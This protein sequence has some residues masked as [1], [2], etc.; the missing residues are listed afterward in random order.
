MLLI[1]YLQ[2]TGEVFVL[3]MDKGIKEEVRVNEIE[4]SGNQKTKTKVTTEVHKEK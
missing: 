3:G 1:C 2:V 4:K